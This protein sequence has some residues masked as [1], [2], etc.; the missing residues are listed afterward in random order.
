MKGN[1]KKK[2]IIIVIN[3]DSKLP[4]VQSMPNIHVNLLTDIEQL[5]GSILKEQYKGSVLYIENQPSHPRNKNK[6]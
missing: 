5:W 1:W 3:S 4:F 6:K 2:K